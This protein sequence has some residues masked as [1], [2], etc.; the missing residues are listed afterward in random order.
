MGVVNKLEELVFHSR[1]L[2]SIE[3]IKDREFLFKM[4]CEIKVLGDTECQLVNGQGTV[5]RLMGQG[6]QVKEYGD[7]YVKV[8][9][10]NI[11]SF[12]IERADHE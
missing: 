11:T 12:A 10:D 8:V 3:I 1:A 2:A 6:L 7:T 4:P 9:G 5:Y